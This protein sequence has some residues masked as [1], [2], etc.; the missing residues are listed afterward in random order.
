M[1]QSIGSNFS[2]CW[3]LIPL[4]CPGVNSVTLGLELSTEGT[5]LWGNHAE[6]AAMFCPF[7]GQHLGTVQ[8]FC[9]SCGKNVQFLA[10]VEHNTSDSPT[11]E[12]SF[13]NTFMMASATM[14]FWIFWKLPTI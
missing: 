7:C 1:S 12:T 10:E 11:E 6:Y 3:S 8:V 2:F 4:G 5:D 13:V 9:G 14:T